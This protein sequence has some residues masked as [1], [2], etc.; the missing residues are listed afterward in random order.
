MAGDVTLRECSQR[1]GHALI[2]LWGVKAGVE[3]EAGAQALFHEA[4]AF[5]KDQAFFAAFPDAA[6]VLELFVGGA[7]DEHCGKA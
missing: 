2:R 3:C 5:D 4:L 7:G 1:G 6:G